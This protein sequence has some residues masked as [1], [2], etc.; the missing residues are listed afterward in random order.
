MSHLPPAAQPVD[1][2]EVFDVDGEGLDVDGG[3]DAK[4]DREQGLGTAAGG[5]HLAGVAQRTLA[6]GRTLQEIEQVQQV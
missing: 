2:Q 4:L 3:I 6:L 1:L 5:L